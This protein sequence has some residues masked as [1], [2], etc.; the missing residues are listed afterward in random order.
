M[1]RLPALCLEWILPESRPYGRVA[2]TGLADPPCRSVGAVR[3]PPVGTCRFRCKTGGS[4]AAPTDGDE[5]GQHALTGGPTQSR[6]FAAGNVQTLES[7]EAA[8][9]PFGQA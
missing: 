5:F 9:G 1:S 2:Q 8:P 4:R 3:E 6:R 7:C